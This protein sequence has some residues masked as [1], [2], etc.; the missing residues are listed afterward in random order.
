MYDSRQLK[1]IHLK[2]NFNSVSDQVLRETV[3]KLHTYSAF[4]D[5]QV[6]LLCTKKI[7]RSHLNLIKLSYSKK[8]FSLLNL[9]FIIQ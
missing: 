7:I 3:V 8:A 5:P 1:T 6:L 9:L 2:S 4:Y